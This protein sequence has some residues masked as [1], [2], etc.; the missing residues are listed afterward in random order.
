VI[1][2][3]LWK[4]KML[5][6]GFRRSVG[7]VVHW[8]V[9][10]FFGCGFAALGF[11]VSDLGFPRNALGSPPCERPPGEKWRQFNFSVE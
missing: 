1:V 7:E 5:S 11:R 10:L 6:A 3:T 2:T 9:P 8:G 4:A